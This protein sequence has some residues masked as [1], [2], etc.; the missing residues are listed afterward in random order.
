MLLRAAIWVDKIVEWLHFIFS[1]HHING[2]LNNSESVTT[3]SKN[4][5]KVTTETVN[6]SESVTVDGSVIQAETNGSYLSNHIK[7][8]VRVFDDKVKQVERIW[9]IFEK[10]YWNSLNVLYHVYG[11][12]SFF[13]PYNIH[14]II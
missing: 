7:F 14:K 12:E 13:K 2:C 1:C 10:K 4:P 9:K 11:T 8:G 3:V 5:F 6:G